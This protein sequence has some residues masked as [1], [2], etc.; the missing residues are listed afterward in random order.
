MSNAEIRAAK[1]TGRTTLVEIPVIEFGGA[2][3]EHV[4]YKGAA[5][6]DDATLELPTF[7]AEVA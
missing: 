1:R 3:F 6:D 4:C 7:R 5:H 2:E